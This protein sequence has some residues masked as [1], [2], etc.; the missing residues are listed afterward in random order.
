[1]LARGIV[2][3]Q[4]WKP[5]GR[6]DIVTVRGEAG[7]VGASSREGI[8]SVLLFRTGGD[9]TVRGYAFES[10]GVQ[11]GDATVGGRYY[12][13][14]SAEATHYFTPA[15][16]AAAFVDA[17]NANDDLASFRFAL[18]YGIGARVRT[19]IGPLRIDVAYG[20]DTASVRLHMSVGLRF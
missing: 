8:P 7:V 5:L 15:L 17:G 9:T 18:G 13:L 2:K 3:A 14:A 6:D 11:Q 19:P 4:A 20:Q 16:G 12:A 1:V 10:L